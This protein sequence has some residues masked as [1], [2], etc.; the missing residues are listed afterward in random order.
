MGTSPCQPHQPASMPQIPLLTA[1]QPQKWQRSNLLHCLPF[2]QFCDSA[3]SSPPKAFYHAVPFAWNAFSSG[4]P[5]ADSSQ[6]S[7]FTLNDISSEWPFLASAACLFH[8]LCSLI[9]LAVYHRPP[10]LDCKLHEDRDLVCFGHKCISSTCVCSV[11][12]SCLTLHDPMN[13]GPQ[14]SP[15]RG[16]LQAKILEWVAIS[17]SRDLPNPGIKPTSPASPALAGRFFTMSTTWGAPYMH[18]CIW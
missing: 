8:N 14:G 6:P 9:S 7:G 5:K 15:V 3:K 4:L 18:I 17:S 12:E 11:A 10:S 16:I 13:C 2:F 1:L